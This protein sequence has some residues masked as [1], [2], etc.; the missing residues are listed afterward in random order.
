MEQ[1]LGMDAVLSV[2]ESA[3]PTFVGSVIDPD[4][5]HGV[6]VRD[7]LLLFV[8]QVVAKESRASAHVRA[9]LVR[10]QGQRGKYGPLTQD[11]PPSPGDRVLSARWIPLGN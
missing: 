7:R 4:A 11:R 1:S 6:V 10:G 5:I 8:E 9:L 2:S 3:A